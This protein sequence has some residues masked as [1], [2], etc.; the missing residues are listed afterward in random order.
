[1]ARVITAIGLALVL[2]PILFVNHI[3]PMVALGFLLVCGA[4]FEYARL[5]KTNFILTTFISFVTYI[6]A[7][8]L[9]TNHNIMI[10]S[11]FSIIFISLILIQLA[12]VS[13]VVLNDSKLFIPH[14][15]T[16]LLYIGLGF[17]AFVLL[18]VMDMKLIIYLIVVIAITDSFAFFFGVKYGKNKI[19]PTISPKKSVEGSVA[20]LIG[21]LI[22]GVLFV[23]FSKLYGTLIFNNYI[24]VI[25]ITIL[26][27]SLGQIGDLFASKIKRKYGVKD[28][29]NLFPG[30]GGVLDRFDSWIIGSMVL[31]AFLLL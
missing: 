16:S 13:Y 8:Y 29:S 4:S 25:L 11:V 30:H 19:A 5:T 21:G 31:L 22:A 14:Y 6:V 15:L 28:F 2:I 27:S 7:I 10:S 26:I 12:Y 1:M 9:Y 24:I 3:F 18:K 20:G 17:S 23:Y